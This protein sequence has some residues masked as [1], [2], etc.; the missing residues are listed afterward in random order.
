MFH[1]EPHKA[2]AQL[3]T[4][5]AF[6]FIS[7]EVRNPSESNIK[8]V[9]LSDF[10]RDSINNEYIVKD[11]NSTL[12]VHDDECTECLEAHVDSGTIFIPEYVALQMRDCYLDKKSKPWFGRDLFVTGKNYANV[13]LFDPKW[14]NGDTINYGPK[15]KFHGRVI[16]ISGYGLIFRLDSFRVNK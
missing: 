10:I 7:C 1:V 11:T 3:L 9:S 8:D 15:Y 16:G 4:C 5:W 13:H 2:F 14:Y 6:L 12:F